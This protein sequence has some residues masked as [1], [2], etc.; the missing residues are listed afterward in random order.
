VPGSRLTEE[1]LQEMVRLRHI[2]IGPTLLAERFGIARSSVWAVLA[3]AT[4][5][6]PVSQNVS[7][8]SDSSNQELRS[9]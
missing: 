6:A 7:Q 1:Q 8:N 9:G 3:R 4:S 5:R 2:G